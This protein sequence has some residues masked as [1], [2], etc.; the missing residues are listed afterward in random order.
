MKTKGIEMAVVSR[1]MAKEAALNARR[2]VRDHV[3]GL[4]QVGVSLAEAKRTARVAVLEG[5]IKPLLALPMADGAERRL[6]LEVTR[7]TAH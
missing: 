7:L 1:K 3:A 2:A 6:K 5:R 4:L